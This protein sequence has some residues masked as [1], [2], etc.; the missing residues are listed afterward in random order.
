ME[1]FSAL[2]SPWTVSFILR[3]N[4]ASDIAP[5]QGLAKQA[6]RENVEFGYLFSRYEINASKDEFPLEFLHIAKRNETLLGEAPLQ[7]FSPNLMQLQ[8]ECEREL[9]GL[10]M[11]CKHELI[12][13]QQEMNS[14]RFFSRANA[15]LLPILYGIYYLVCKEYPKNHEEIY[16]AFPGIRIPEATKNL[17]KLMENAN[18]YIESI[19]AIINRLNTAKF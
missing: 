1:G 9:R 16:A 3:S 19:A 14:H 17:Q 2:E 13:I 5:L 12:T 11:H 6:K 7:D 8:K 15:A 10:L 4:S 18:T